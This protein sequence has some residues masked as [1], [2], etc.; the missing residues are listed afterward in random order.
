MAGT[1]DIRS[2]VRALDIMELVSNSPAGL[3]LR[4]LSHAFALPRQTV[5]GLVRT[6]IRKK[7]LTKSAPPVRYMVG[8][9]MAALQQRQIEWNRDVLCRAIPP[10]IKLGR[11]HA[12]I[13]MIAQYT[14]GR[15]LGRFFCAGDD[16]GPK[17]LYNSPVAEYGCS[18]VVQAFM[19]APELAAY[20]S[21]NAFAKADWDYWRCP[22]NLDALYALIR[23]VGYLAMV[24]SGVF[25]V[26]APILNS[27]G[28][29]TAMLGI[30]KPYED[31]APGAA[32]ASI[33]ATVS[34][35]R[36]VSEAV[37]QA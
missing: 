27:D 18:L 28:R 2:V 30:T 11:D 33:D 19:E 12:A 20:R 32:R 8:P 9:M 7:Y 16:E 21:Q 24:K 22:E 3:T 35:A 4:Q 17:L 1:K 13:V 31:L 14:G 36:K 6:L 25:R 34:A 10:A 15:I 26:A 23:E 29:P 37:K 5:H